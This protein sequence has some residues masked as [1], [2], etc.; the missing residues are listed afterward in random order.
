MK[1]KKK[2]KTKIIYENK[3]DDDNQNRDKR[4]RILLFAIKIFGSSFHFYRM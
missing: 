3:R 2:H 1:T 4:N